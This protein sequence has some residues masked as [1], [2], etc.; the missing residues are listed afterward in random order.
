M[1]LRVV[2]LDVLELRRVAERV[3]VPVQLAHPAVQVRVPGADV[4]QVA[5]EVLHVHGIEA[6]DGRVQPDVGLGQAGAEVVR[7]PPFAVVQRQVGLGA[8]EGPEE[9]GDGF[10]VG[11]GGGGEA[12]LVDAVVDLVVGP[13][14]S[15]VDFGAEGLRVEVDGGVVRGEEAVEGGVEHAEDLRGLVGD[16]ARG[17]GV[18]EG[19]HQEA[20]V[21]GGVLGEV[22]VAE[23]GE[24]RVD[25]VWAHVGAG[26]GLVGRGE[27]P[28]CGRY[29][30][31]GGC[32]RT[33]EV[34]R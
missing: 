15:S 17:L 25:G 30:G 11:R 31:L 20:A 19:G 34:E 24:V 32:W 12:G 8:V 4:A 13:F 6:H 9:G 27:A 5:L 26:E 21:V 22:N 3:L 1:R 16:D 14:V 10:L 7:T 33:I 2:L 18:V 28:A 29:Q 23:V